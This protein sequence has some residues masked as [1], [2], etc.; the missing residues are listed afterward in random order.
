MPA[1]QYG[2]LDNLTRILS[3][4]VVGFDRF[5]ELLGLDKERACAVAA[6]L[7]L[8]SRRA[9]VKHCSIS[10]TMC[11]VVCQALHVLKNLPYR[12]YWYL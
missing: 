2:H 11:A 1:T 8:W 10:P 9:L 6:V 5:E 4:R 7:R 3:I 12:P